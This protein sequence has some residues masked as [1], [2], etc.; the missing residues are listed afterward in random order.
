VWSRPTSSTEAC[1]STTPATTRRHGR[2]H[3][4]IRV[5]TL[6]PHGCLV[7]TRRA[8]YRFTP[9]IVGRASMLECCTAPSARVPRR[10][11]RWTIHSQLKRRRG[12]DDCSPP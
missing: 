12:R 5:N 2:R 8:E 7:P 1:W 10:R 3:G 4:K 9:S 6:L 11:H